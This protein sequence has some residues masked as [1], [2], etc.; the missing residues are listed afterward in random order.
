MRMKLKLNSNGSAS[1]GK[2]FKLGYCGDHGGSDEICVWWE[3]GGRRSV[4][5][6]CGRQ[7]SC[8]SRCEDVF[9]LNLVKKY[10]LCSLNAMCKDNAAI[11]CITVQH[12][13]KFNSRYRWRE[14]VIT[15][16][17]LSVSKAISFHNS[18]DRSLL[19]LCLLSPNNGCLSK[20]KQIIL[21]YL[22]SANLN[23]DVK[24]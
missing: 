23:P 3:S 21:I 8:F 7:A 11:N 9:K 17:V 16:V 10:K 24:C 1:G 12:R 4:S 18:L 2:K 5:C 19:W 6:W 22:L 20:T 15:L 14:K 13:N